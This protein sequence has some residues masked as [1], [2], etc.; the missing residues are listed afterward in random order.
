M[1]RKPGRPVLNAVSWA[2]L[3]TVFEW[4]RG[5]WPLGG[6][7]WGT[8][9]ISQV[10]NHATVRLA[11]VAGVWGVSF[12]VVLVNGLILAAAGGG[13]GRRR[14]LAA[15]IAVLAVAIPIVIPFGHPDGRL[16]DVATLQV[17]V[18]QAASVNPDNE[19]IGV[20]QLNI[21][22]HARLASDPPDLAVWGEGALDPAATSDPRTMAAVR[23]VVARVGVPTL[24][25]AVKQD[26]DGRERTSVLLLDAHGNLAGRYDKVH[27]V[28]YGDLSPSAT[29]SPGSRP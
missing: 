29:S 16:L 10:N 13:E 17:D 12:V 2:A 4:L 26:P 22:E 20:A 5:L 14:L 28:P 27:L 24:I 7:T 23:R 3:W 15:G 9:G 1:I 25:G 18:R 21:A 11:T 6:F 19:D 8:L